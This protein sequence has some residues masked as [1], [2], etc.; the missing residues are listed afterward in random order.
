MTNDWEALIEQMLKGSLRALSRLISRVENRENGW[1]NAMKNIYPYTGSTFMIGITGP[2]G[3]GKSTLTNAVIKTLV[4]EGKR[5]GIIAVDPSSPFSGG[6]L[7]GDRLR[8]RDLWDLDEVF[9][10]SMATRGALGGMNQSARDIAK[11][12]DAY[13]KDFVL[14]ETVGVGQDEIEVVKS[15]DLVI[16]VCVPGQGDSIQALKAGVMEIADIFV[17]NKADLEGANELEMDI[18][19][20]LDLK[21][22]G[23][24]ISRTP[25]VKTIAT[26]NKG[27]GDLIAA[28]KKFISAHTLRPDWQRA[29]IGE[30]L[31]GLVEKELIAAIT[32]SWKKENQLDRVID[33]ILDGNSDPY[34]A[35]EK[36]LSFF[37]RCLEENEITGGTLLE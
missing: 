13:G 18:Q 14:I 2:P 22:A 8:M 29:R 24:A 21:S 7:L 23:G 12:L 31:I 9:I 37:L 27:I 1:I 5:V 30:E 32:H 10:R 4:D 19:A 16:M 34:S 26:Q 35:A 20:M 28:I 6:S 33:Q 3:A 11:I 17:I 25:I 36:A 15:T